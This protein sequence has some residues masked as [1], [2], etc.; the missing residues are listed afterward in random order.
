MSML[1]NCRCA[2][3]NKVSSMEIQTDVGDFSDKPFIWDE[4]NRDYIC[5]DCKEAHETLML[6]YQRQDELTHGW[7]RVWPLH[8][9]DNDNG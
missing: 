6:D 7:L 9:K 4:Q 1:T 2:V 5:T 8:H 3:C